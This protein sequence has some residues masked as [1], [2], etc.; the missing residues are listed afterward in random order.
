MTSMK[1]WL[2]AAGLAALAST[3]QAGSVTIS[4]TI[5]ASDPSMDAVLIT[6]PTCSYQGSTPVRYEAIPFT[7]DQSG[8]Y[9]FSMT[10][11]VGV[12][13]LYLFEN[14]FNPAD[15]LPTCM[16][17]DNSGNPVE[18]SFALTAGTPYI[19]VPFDDTFSQGGVTYALTISG[20]GNIAVTTVPEPAGIFLV[21]SALLAL[22]GLGTHR[23]RVRSSGERA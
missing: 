5:G 6:T 23:R 22:V 3:A 7:V 1:T 8:P 15:P 13:S 19:S 21:G 16:A 20:P 18:F 11:L 2:I 17:A 10:S 4:G 12:G 9:Q 14:S